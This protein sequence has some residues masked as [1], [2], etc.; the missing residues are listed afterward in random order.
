MTIPTMFSIGVMAVSA[1]ATSAAWQTTAAER[2]I[3]T[4]RITQPVM[5]EG[6]LLPEGMYQLVLTGERPTPLPGQA[7]DAQ[8]WV[9]FVAN[10]KPVAR[11]IAEVLRDSD[12]PA[13][14]ASARPTRD[15]VR[16][17]MLQGGEFLRISVKRE[18]ERYL[19]HL[20]VIRE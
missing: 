1:L 18:G 10:G 2:E 12:L 17:E 11:E 3:A 15:G 5:A 20:P 8:R 16:V 14:G 19:V 6:K 9:A 13:T 4:V 7:P